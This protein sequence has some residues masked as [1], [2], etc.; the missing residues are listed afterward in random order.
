ML[1]R[2]HSGKESSC[3][4]R[5]RRRQVQ[6]LDQEDP[7]EEEMATYSSILAWDSPWTEESGGVHGV[8]KSQTQLRTHACARHCF[9]C[10]FRINS[11]YLPSRGFPSFILYV[12][13]QRH[14]EVND[15]P[16]LSSTST[17]QLEILAFWSTS[18]VIHTPP[19]VPNPSHTESLRILHK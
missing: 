4:R 10:S 11:F 7:L 9:Q 18:P 14:W 12:R 2:W 5:R 19:W 16:M 3:Q 6:F 13:S 15:L 1:P 17:R 8:T